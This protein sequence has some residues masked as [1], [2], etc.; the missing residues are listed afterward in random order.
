MGMEEAFENGQPTLKKILQRYQESK[1]GT[2]TKDFDFLVNRNPLLEKIFIGADCAIAIFDA[3]K[4]NYPYISYK[5]E[6]LLG[7]EAQAY[8]QEGLCFTLS[9]IHPD[10]VP[11]L[12]EIL[13]KEMDYIAGLTPNQRLDYRSSYDYRIRKINGTYI[14]VLQRNLILNLD[15]AN[16]VLHL[17]V[18][19]TDITHLKKDNTKILH[20]INK[21]ESGFAYF[22]N[23]AEQRVTKDT[24]LSK[25][26][27]E[28]L[29]LLG[30]GYSSK[31]VADELFIS[32]HTVE[33]HRRNMLEKTNIK[34]TS[35]LVHF[36][37]LAGF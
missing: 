14:R 19:L 25:R 24:F 30:K 15:E 32:I 29:K 27:I 2:A 16:Q 5:L 9:K 36:A 28:I 3:S 33:T 13:E 12:L 31:E 21:Q 18:V 7:Y 26:E 37:I 20:I 10:D 22:Y 1:P 11:G 8:L 4:T 6:Q 17:L 35:C 34:D 23:L